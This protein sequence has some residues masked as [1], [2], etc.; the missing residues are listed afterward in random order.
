MRELP[1]VRALTDPAPCPIQR[2]RRR[3]RRLVRHKSTAILQSAR[4]LSHFV[5]LAKGADV[6]AK[7]A[8]KAALKGTGS[9]TSRKVRTSTTFHRPT[10]LRLA[11]KP[12]YPRKSV[13]HAPRLD[14]YRFGLRTPFQGREADMG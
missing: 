6:K 1:T 8:K 14:Q 11:R 10:T 13:P 9:H 4:K 12:R 5:S 2:S 7:A 3:E